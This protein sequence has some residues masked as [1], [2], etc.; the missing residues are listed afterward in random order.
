[1]IMTMRH[2]PN[3]DS[4]F[5][6][7][8]DESG[9]DN[10]SEVAVVGGL[11]LDITQLYWFDQEWLKVLAAHK[12]DPPLHMCEFGEGRRLGHL[13]SEARRA[14]F[15][16]VVKTINSNKSFSIA[17]WITSD[18]YR[19]V[20]DGVSS[21]S[22]YAAAFAQLMMAIG[23]GTKTNNFKTPVR[24]MLDDGN[25]YKMEAENAHAFMERIPDAENPVGELKFDLDHNLSALQAADVVSWTVRRRRVAKLKS[26]F[27]PLEE[28]CTEMH[29]EI[30]YKKEWMETVAQTL[31]ER[32]QTLNGL[33]CHDA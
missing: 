5:T 11:V 6:C 24:Y 19:S 20:F 7:F 22:M 2:R 30:P 1:M 17:A 31:R 27:E 25:A 28:L 10:N 8:L 13:R 3:R 23:I 29:D 26:G 16:D 18:E 12:I 15:V 32:K 9:T 33:Y 14:L 21:F 4:L